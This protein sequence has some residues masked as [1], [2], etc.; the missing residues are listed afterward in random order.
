MSYK[1][2]EEF[3]E[4]LDTGLWLKILKLLS[5]EKKN[6]FMAISFMFME[7]LIT[8]VLPIFN[9]YAIDNFFGGKGTDQQILFF[10]LIY[11]VLVLFQAFLIFQFINK[12]GIIEM[13]IS[14]NTRKNAMKKLQNQSFSYYDVTPSGWIMARVTS[15]IARLS[16]ILSWS[17]IDLLWG[18]FFMVIMMI[19][20]IIV[21]WK[22]A[23]IVIAV[24]PVVYL[25]ST[26]VQ[27]TLLKHYRKVRAVN[28]QI[29]SGFSE[30]IS[31]AKTTKTMALEELHYSE[32]SALTSEMKERSMRTVIIN[33]IYIPVVMLL[34]SFSSA[35]ILWA[36]GDMVISGLIQVG[37]LV[38]FTQFA[39]QFFEPLRNIAGILAQMQMAQASA[40]RV[41]SMIEKEVAL[42]DS[43]EVIK[44]YGTILEPKVENYEDIVGNIEFKDVNFHYN[45]EEPILNNFNLKIEPKQRIALVGE[46]GSG[47]STLVN[48]IC[49]FYEP[50][51][52]KILI[53]G[54]D[55]KDRS[56]GWLHSHLGYVLQ[57]PHLFSGTVAENVRYGR[58]DAT[59][60]EI[61]EV[62]KL[63]DA[64]EFISELE[65]GYNT[66]VGE[67]GNRLSTGQKQLIS[68]ARALI[69]NPSIFVLD[70]ATSSIDT[71]TE[72]IIQNAVDNILKEK[73]S[74]II[75]HRL[76][77]IVNAD[78]ILVMKNGEIIEDGTHASLMKQKGYYYEL[79][80]HQFN[81]EQEEQRTQEVLDS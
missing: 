37:T 38:M 41:I 26:L 45:P 56:L 48:L 31:G 17:L 53:D 43:E 25:I 30:G 61:K 62:C 78:R 8:A 72:A 16:E 19:T 14:Y 29:T 58:L 81:E 79:Y 54:V 33:S 75:A 73:T 13:S 42:T 21:N 39:N 36:G 9:S 47:K 22:L 66:D 15:D 55:Y 64:D 70:E 40:E 59:D 51:E 24:M 63:I 76:S 11:G 2:E 32:F 5:H 7:A 4:K 65:D 46:T 49:R 68:L 27:K 23:V 34:S 20:M 6:L 18:S 1:K 52:G 12:C 60:E 44:K 57:A 50:K 80:T 3:S 71:E 10:G 35:G 77:T 28:S 69:S 67:G 74:F